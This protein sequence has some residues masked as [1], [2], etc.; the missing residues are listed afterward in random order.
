MPIELEMVLRVLLAMVL[1]GILGFQRGQAEKP[2]G[3]RDLI[4]I[5]A[6]AALFTVVS[7]YGFGIT[8]QARVAAGIVTGIGFLGA[9]VILRR[10]DS[11]VVKGL[12]TAATI[13]ITAGIGMAAGSGMYILAV[14]VTVMVFLVLILPWRFNK[15]D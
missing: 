2:A 11:N 9:G 13:W 8:D 6:G 3:L 14:A 15:K 5:C 12:T 10:D 1:G 7:V 4:L